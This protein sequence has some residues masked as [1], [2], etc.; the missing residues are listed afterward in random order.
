MRLRKFVFTFGLMAALCAP[1][2][3][4]VKFERKFQEGSTKTSEVTTRTEQKLTINGME[5]ETESDARIT[6]TSTTGKRDDSGNIRVQEKITGLMITTK[7][8]G[9]EYVFDSS[10]PDKAGGSALEILRPVHKLLSG[11]TSTSVYD[12]GNKIAQVEFDQDPLAGLSDDVRKLVKDEFDAEKIKK[13][14]NE[15]MERIPTEAVKKGDAWERTTKRSLGA[16][17][18]LTATTRFTYEGEIQKDGKTLDKIT[19]KVLSVDLTLEDSPLPLTIKSTDLKPTESKG[20]LLFDRK[21]GSTVS[22][23]SSVRIVGDITFVINNMELPSKLDLK[24]E[25]A[26]QPKE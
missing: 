20:E 2:L 12:K 1:A 11:R 24:M 15:E 3:A 14:A 16:G 18:I 25:T 22:G 4:Q 8:Q 19:S 23:T 26:S 13:N 17:Q 6:V 5:T 7:V 9:T 21:L 10:N